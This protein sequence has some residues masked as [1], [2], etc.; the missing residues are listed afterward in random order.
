MKILQEV[1]RARGSYVTLVNTD[2]Q[3]GAF[4]AFC[5]HFLDDGAVVEWFVVG[6]KSSTSFS[7]WF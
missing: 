1:R 4:I 7:R 5:C 3:A 2:D 6:R